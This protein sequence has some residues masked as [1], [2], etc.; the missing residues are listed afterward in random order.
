[1]T[2]SV[3]VVDDEPL[4]RRGILSRLSRRKDVSVIAECANGR[5]AIAA[6]RERSPDLVFLDVKMPGLDG[7]AVLREI[8]S[9][10]APH[11]IFVTA[12]DRHAL[13]AF[14][15]HAMDYL[16]KPIDDERFDEAVDRAI[17]MIERERH[18]ELGRQVV[19]L[20]AGTP[21]GPGKTARA[22]MSAA[23]DHY[24]VRTKGRVVLLRHVEIDWV[25]AEGDYVRIHTGE[26]SWLVR[27][28]MTSVERD[29]PARRFLR[30]HRSTLV[31]VDRVRE[32]R[33]FDTGDSAVVLRDGTQ[34][35]LGRSYR[36]AVERLTR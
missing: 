13:K 4:G 29:L 8:V 28:T 1:V 27:A 36:E 14:D 17:A 35:R 23:S 33:S 10:P 24:A 11:I 18:E 12:F 30:I 26:R 21:A 22:K 34:L 31:A 15:V 7:F 19:S 2:V 6:I 5:E 9:S 32:V 3:A 16:L 20:V 25:G